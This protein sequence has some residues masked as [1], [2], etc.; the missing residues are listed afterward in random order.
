MEHVRLFTSICDVSQ[1]GGGTVISDASS[2]IDIRSLELGEPD[3]GVILR[4][5]NVSTSVLHGPEI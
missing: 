1:D 3:N 4:G 5:Y 2:K